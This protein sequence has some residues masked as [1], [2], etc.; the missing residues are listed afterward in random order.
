MAKWNI[1][2]Q[3]KKYYT[4]SGTS[5]R[6]SQM[7]AWKIKKGTMSIENLARNI[8]KSNPFALKGLFSNAEKEFVRLSRNPGV[9]SPEKLMQAITTAYRS[10]LYMTD[11]GRLLAENLKEI[12]PQVMTEDEIT[13]MKATFNQEYLN[14][15]DWTWNSTVKR[16]ESPD[17]KH[18]IK[19]VKGSKSNGYMGTTIDYE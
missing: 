12:I 1:K 3:N 16:L 10:A 2:E 5:L 17:E 9:T 11:K 6:Y 14:F 15:D 18:W 19:V 13:A 8:A 7:T 4:I